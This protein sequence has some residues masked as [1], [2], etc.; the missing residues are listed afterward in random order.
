MGALPKLHAAT[1]AE[2]KGG[3]KHFGPTTGGNARGCRGPAGWQT[4]GLNA[5]T[6]RPALERSANAPPPTGLGGGGFFLGFL[7]KRAPPQKK[8]K[9]A[10]N[11]NMPRDHLCQKAKRAE[12]VEFHQGLTPWLSMSHWEK[13]GIG[14][15]FG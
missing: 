7:K 10:V 9:K 1:A 6:R 15:G 14:S 5:E 11:M 3:G 2:A 8:K 12:P 13:G 4:K